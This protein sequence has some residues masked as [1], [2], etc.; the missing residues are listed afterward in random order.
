MERPDF[1]PSVERLSSA[2]SRQEQHKLD[3]AKH[4][5]AEKALEAALLEEQE[6]MVARPSITE[7]LITEQSE[8]SEEE[9]AEV[10]VEEEVT[11]ESGEIPED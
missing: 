9:E 7:T 8:A 2:L 6:K 4:A 1:V 10:V 5:A 11:E 3:K